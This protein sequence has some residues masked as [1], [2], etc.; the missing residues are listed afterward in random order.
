MSEGGRSRPLSRRARRI[1]GRRV[2]LAGALTLLVAGCGIRTRPPIT[3]AI[4][5]T[6]GIDVARSLE[7]RY[8]FCSREAN[9]TTTTSV[10]IDSVAELPLDRLSPG[11]EIEVAVAESPRRLVVDYAT[12]DGGRAEVEWS[13]ERRRCGV[14]GR[15]VRCNREVERGAA[16]GV[17]SWRAT[18][19]F[20]HLGDGGLRIGDHFR[21]CGL[22]F[23][24]VPFCESNES[25]L[26]LPP[27]TKEGCACP[28]E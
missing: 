13:L 11:G 27:A 21:E 1:S 14:D 20:S 24:V 25:A 18:T 5:S 15:V 22:A 6:E 9:L 7:G 17:G 23:L 28:G 10:E 3:A 8:C 19:D 2:L 16:M 12:L 26:E 4:D